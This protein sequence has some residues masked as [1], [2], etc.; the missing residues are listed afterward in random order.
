MESRGPY[1]L[2]TQYSPCATCPYPLAPIFLKLPHSDRPYGPATSQAPHQ[3]AG[4]CCARKPRTWCGLAAERG[5]QCVRCQHAQLAVAQLLHA[6]RA[7]G[8]QL[9]LCVAAST[10]P[11]HAPSQPCQARLGALAS[12]LCLD[13][14]APSIRMFGEFRCQGYF[15]EYVDLLVFLVLSFYYF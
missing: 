2:P 3:D 10:V 6:P 7:R 9:L 14:F 12:H 1:L 5:C 11:Q 8:C 13:I 4:C 15:W